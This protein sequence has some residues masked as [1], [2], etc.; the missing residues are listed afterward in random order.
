MPRRLTKVVSREPPVRNNVQKLVK[1]D[2]KLGR[3]SG[4]SRDF[5]YRLPKDTVILSAWSNN[6]DHWELF[7]EYTDTK[8]YVDAAFR[9]VSPWGAYIEEGYVFICSVVMPGTTSY[10]YLD[11]RAVEQQGPPNNYLLYVKGLHH[12]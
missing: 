9:L 5:V 8:H 7:Y 10:V 1:F 11:G 3:I 4:S 12:D 6:Y 2:R